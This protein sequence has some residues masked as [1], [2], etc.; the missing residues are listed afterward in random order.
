[1]KANV[2]QRIEGGFIGIV[3]IDGVGRGG[4]LLLPVGLL[5]R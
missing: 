5:W 2:R 4:R 1:M 3:F